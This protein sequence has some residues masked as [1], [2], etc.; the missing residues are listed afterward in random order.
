VVR[1]LRGCAYAGII[2]FFLLNPAHASVL[3]GDLIQA[4]YDYPTQGA[5]YG[6]S[7]VTPNPFVVGPGLETVISIE[8]VTFLNVDF[9]DDSLLITLLTVL[10]NPTWNSVPQNG[11]A[12]EVLSGNPFPAISQVTSTS[13]TVTAFLSSGKLFINWAGM[14]YHTGDTVTV[15]F[16]TPL[17]AAL[18]L[19]A[20]GL[21]GFGIFGWSRGRKK[22]R[23]T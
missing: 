17:P 4:E 3:T 16:E 12:F 21:T 11:P 7:T 10:D 1:Y 23:V 2:S 22:S 13:G 6:A 9:S 20:T 19:F 18:P 8:D 15:S 14:P 5:V